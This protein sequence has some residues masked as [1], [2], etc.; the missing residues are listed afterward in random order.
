MHF[1]V[2]AVTMIGENASKIQQN[3]SIE[4]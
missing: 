3:T 4:I 2:A 1:D